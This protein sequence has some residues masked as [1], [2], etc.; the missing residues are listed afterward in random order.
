MLS[1]DEEALVGEVLKEPVTKLSR[2][3]IIALAVP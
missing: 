2:A 3:E 1:G